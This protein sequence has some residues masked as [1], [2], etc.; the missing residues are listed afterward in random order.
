MS[1][2]WNNILSYIKLG[3]GAPLNL[4]EFSDEELIQNL[5]EHVLPFFSQL[6]RVHFFED[7]FCYVVLQ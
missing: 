1:Q 2:S 3:L 4:L 5:K 6:L 7:K